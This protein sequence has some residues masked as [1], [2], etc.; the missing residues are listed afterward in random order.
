M[1]RTIITVNN[2]TVTRDAAILQAIELNELNDIPVEVCNALG[3][4]IYFV[5][6]DG[7]ERY[8]DL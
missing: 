8:Y 1:K 4:T 7:T 5:D 2:T 6:A 3:D